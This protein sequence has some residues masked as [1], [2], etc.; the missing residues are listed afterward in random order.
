MDKK[1]QIIPLNTTDEKREE[2]NYVPVDTLLSVLTDI[3]QELA[4][5]FKYR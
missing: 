3:D 5:H 4:H 2:G 1:T